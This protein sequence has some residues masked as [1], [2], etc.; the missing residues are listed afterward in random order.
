MAGDPSPAASL[1]I[2]RRLPAAGADI[3]E[4]GLPFSD[5]M[6][7][8]PSIQ[9]AAIRALSAGMTLTGVLNLARAFRET[10]QT[11]PLVLMGYLNPLLSR[12]LETFAAEAASA[13]VDGV[14]VVDCPPEEAEPLAD[15]L[16]AAGLDLIR[17]ATPTTDA[18]RLAV[19]ARR[20]SGF[21]YYVSV[22]GVT[23]GKSVSAVDIAPAV[24]RV[25]EA[26]GLPVAVGFGIRTPEQAR[27][28][29]EVADAAVVGSALVEI[30]E[31]ETAAGRDPAN[32]VAD[33]VFALSRAVRSAR[34]V[35]A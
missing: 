16:A 12:G 32:A 23:G 22:N 30:V 8:G 21:V 1:D 20:T 11:T 17:L 6:A 18:A 14:I 26:T 28:V 25:R 4:L 27:A 7:D 9:R 33:A 10:D 5:P 24:A 34:L 31:A 19:V 35:E 2:L 15:A 29:A 3:I 13:G